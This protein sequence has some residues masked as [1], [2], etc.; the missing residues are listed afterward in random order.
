MCKFKTLG[1]SWPPKGWKQ[2][3]TIKYSSGQAILKNPASAL[4]TGISYHVEPIPV[5]SKEN[6]RRYIYAVKI[7]GWDYNIYNESREYSVLSYVLHEKENSAAPKYLHISDV[8]TQAQALE[9]TERSAHR[10]FMSALFMIKQIES[11]VVPEVER[12]LKLYKI[13]P[14][15]RHL[16]EGDAKHQNSLLPELT[17]K[18]IRCVNSKAI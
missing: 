15:Q 14:T 16:Y 6:I 7:N 13:H 17:G 4:V 1:V 11:G 5:Y 18:I 12:V 10:V 3:E 8:K 2:F 9:I